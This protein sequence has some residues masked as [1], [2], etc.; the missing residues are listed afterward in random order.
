MQLLYRSNFSRT[1]GQV[2]AAFGTGGWQAGYR[3]RGVIRFLTIGSFRMHPGELETG[4]LPQGGFS[5]RPRTFAETT[6]LSTNGTLTGSTQDRYLGGGTVVRIGSMAVEGFY[7]SSTFKALV[8]V[9]EDWLSEAKTGTVRLAGTGLAVP[10]KAGQLRLRLL[11]REKD[12]MAILYP[13]CTLT[14]ARKNHVWGVAAGVCARPAPGPPGHAVLVHCRTAGRPLTLFMTGFHSSKDYLPPLEDNWGRSILPGYGAHLAAGLQPHRI[15][16][17]TAAWLCSR[18]F[19]EEKLYQS[20]NFS[21]LLHLLPPLSLRAVYVRK[22][23]GADSAQIWAPVGFRT[24]LRYTPSSGPQLCLEWHTSRARSGCA[25][26]L[27]GTLAKRFS[28]AFSGRF[29]FAAGSP[30]QDHPLYLPPPVLTDQMLC[31]RAVF[32][33]FGH[34][35][36]PCSTGR[37]RRCGCLSGR[38]I[39]GTGTSMT[40]CCS[41]PQNC[42]HKTLVPH[43]LLLYA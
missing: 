20:F 8:P 12:G 25:N 6:L 4:T 43:T 41:F 40:T 35:P 42:V 30:G 33:I 14:L 39:T 2:R 19:P 28:T 5:S 24:S 23:R 31:G 37:S 3:G 21:A 1:N 29:W 16:A 11:A 36:S 18:R 9:A 38:C 10:H 15:L 27:S 17:L 34:S 7:S 32:P 26:A 22:Q 13:S